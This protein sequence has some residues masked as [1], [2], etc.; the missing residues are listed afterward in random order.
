MAQ[1]L[2]GGRLGFSFA[3]DFSKGPG[4]DERTSP[5]SIV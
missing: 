4:P 3:P 2:A 1:A 5:Y